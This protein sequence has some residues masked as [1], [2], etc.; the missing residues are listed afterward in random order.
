MWRPSG[1]GLLLAALSLA[2]AP[3]LGRCTSTDACLQAIEAAQRET[4]T[5]SAEF[6]Q[7]KHVSLLDEPLTSSGRMVF[8][9][10][11][12]ILL[13]IERPQAVRV[14]INGQDI[15]IPNLPESERQGLSMA[16]MAAMFTQLGAMFTGSSQALRA[17]FDVT[18]RE[19]NDGVQLHLVPREAAWQ[20]MFRSVDVRFAGPDL[21]VHSIGLEDGLGDSLEISLRNVQRNAEVPDA[22]FAHE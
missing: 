15:H 17:G 2:A 21:L 4:R 22:T 14:V 3:A 9:R 13:Q 19:D 8:K 1:V 6:T 11:D 5:I 7:I 18:A 10:P 20:R 16:P 12:H